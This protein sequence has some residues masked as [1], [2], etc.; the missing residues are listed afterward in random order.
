M[1]ARRLRAGVR[2]VFLLLL[3]APVAGRAQTMP[4]P[5]S[6]AD[7][8]AILDQEKPD[9]AKIAARTKEAEAAPPAA[10]SG[11]DLAKFYAARAASAAALGRIGQSVADLNKA[12]GITRPMPDQAELTLAY[13]NLLRSIASRA[14]NSVD[15]I[16]LSRQI[17]DLT[18]GK[19]QPDERTVEA[20]QTLIAFTAEAGKIDNAT[21]QAQQLAQ[22]I[23]QLSQSP[24][25]APYRAGY[26]WSLD[27]ARG[28][29]ALVSG[30]L[31]EAEA[32]FRRATPEGEQAAKDAAPISD[33]LAQSWRSAA[34][35]SN[36]D[37][38]FTLQDE[39][40]LEE[41]EVAARQALLNELDIHGRYAVETVDMVTALAGIVAAEGRYADS[42]KLAQIAIDTYLALGIE[43]S[44]RSF[45][46][47]RGILVADLMGGGDAKDALAQVDLVMRGLAKD[48]DY[49]RRTLRANPA[50]IAAAIRGG[51]PSDAVDWGKA[52]MEE[53]ER[54]FGAGDYRTAIQ[55]GLYADALLAS[56]DIPDARENFAKAVPILL[57]T[58][59]QSLD[60]SGRAR[61]DRWR[62]VVLDGDLYVLAK[63]GSADAAIEAFR[64]ADAARGQT[65]QRAVAQAAARSAARDSA[66]ADLTRREQDA[67][68]QIDAL[69]TALANGY[70]LPSNQ[71]D[72]AALTK[73]R[74][75]ID[76]LTAQRKNMRADLVKQFPDYVRLTNPAP[77][78]IAEAQTALRPGEA[79]LAIYVGPSTIYLWAV[80]K[81]ATPV[82]AVSPLARPDID[83][84]V[85]LLRSAVDPDAATAGD[86]PAFDI[87]SAYKLYAGLLAPVKAGWQGANDLLVVANGSLG[88]IPFGMLTTE[89]VRLAPDKNGQPQFSSY[90]AVPWLIREV[91]I[92]QL[93]SVTS[94]TTLRAMPAATAV[95]K[96][97]IGFGDPWFSPA[98]AAQA[99]AE[100]GAQPQKIAANSTVATRGAPVHLRS[101]PKTEGIDDA[102]LADLPRL[103]DTADEV[104]EVAEALKADPT[105]DVY[106]GAR[107]NEQ[108]V[109]TVDLDDRRVIM[110]ATHGLVPGDLDGLTEPALALSA[111]DVAHVPGDGLLTVSKILGLRLNADWVVL[112]AC[113]TAAGDGAGAEAVSGLGLAFFYAG[114]R[115]L[116]VSNWPVETTSARI[117]T[118]ELFKREAA[119]P[120]IARAE[121][122][123]Q[124]M[125]ALIDGPGMIDPA[126]Q[127]PI[128]SY[129]H[130]IFWAP[131]S[132]VGDGGAG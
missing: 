34:S 67:Q 22:V 124:S 19:G 61:I 59:D 44:A 95:R 46:T 47:A 63:D 114:S 43:P 123:R 129:A 112:S 96:P 3:I 116:L 97:F 117:L 100:Q 132:L 27:R 103:P 118:T 54:V 93:P 35:Y 131:F 72:D 122:L 69:T 73:L 38:A 18:Q 55:V 83:R 26:A 4:P 14:G 105:K 58:A 62:T 78:T 65:V 45:N 40:R 77:A 85:K 127:K 108:V 15:A 41:A 80:K 82:F 39:G 111:P 13:T 53:S 21:A 128:L 90:R 8:T 16:S 125:L 121:A 48:P 86:I 66:L 88:Q 98:E 6:I 84:A 60:E 120:G 36:R 2:I 30:R 42:A 37:L 113:N 101:A 23:G 110:F 76:E 57:D 31:D 56:G 87:A 68:R 32:D 79:L 33:V 119:M 92:T 11:V 25:A 1:I 99:L 106:L 50:F 75:Q 7:I 102:E 20:Y 24:T 89:D 52:A 104:K 9:A 49:I 51:R 10:L 107:A 91:A 12:L 81:D 94:L 64:V 130:P 109:R 29:I 70:A 17:I 28:V 74:A 71:R 5:Q 126:T 115:A